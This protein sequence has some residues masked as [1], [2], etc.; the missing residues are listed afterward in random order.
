MLFSPYERSYAV[1]FASV[2]ARFSIDIV[3]FFPFSVMVG[4][5]V[6][7]IMLEFARLSC[8][9]LAA[10]PVEFVTKMSNVRLP[11]GSL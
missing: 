11:F 3:S 8:V 7:M 6:S 4:G 1:A 2:Y 5:I 9:T 10:Y